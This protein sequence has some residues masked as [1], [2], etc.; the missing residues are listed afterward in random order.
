MITLPVSVHTDQTV[1]V[2]E[3]EELVLTLVKTGSPFMRGSYADRP[4]CVKKSEICGGD[5]RHAK[6]E[7]LAAEKP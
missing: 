6:S 2:F 4:E 5:F 3:D 1:A 7:T